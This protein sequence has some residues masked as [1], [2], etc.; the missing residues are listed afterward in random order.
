[1]QKYLLGR[2]TEEA[3][4]PTLEEVL[5]WAGGHAG[6]TLPLANAAATV[7]GERDAR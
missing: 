6:G 5:G 4:Q 1:M 7:R 3:R 2:L